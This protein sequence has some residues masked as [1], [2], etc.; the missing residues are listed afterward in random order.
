MRITPLWRLSEPGRGAAGKAAP[1]FA[2]MRRKSLCSRQGRSESGDHRVLVN[3]LA[4]DRET[5]PA[6]NLGCPI[7]AVSRF[8]HYIATVARLDQT[9]TRAQVRRTMRRLWFAILL[10]ISLAVSATASAWAAQACPYKQA[11][12]LSAS[13]DCCPGQKPEPQPSDHHGKSLDCQLGQ[14]CR[15]AHAVE[16]LEPM[17]TIAS[18]EVAVAYLRAIS[19]RSHTTAVPSGLWR[20][21]RTA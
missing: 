2:R 4:W 16:P 1:L 9:G 6:R 12:Q 15:T 14:S 3:V 19:S 13:H 21:P 11:G 5:C 10:V 8:T 20:P 7:S 18:A 17:L